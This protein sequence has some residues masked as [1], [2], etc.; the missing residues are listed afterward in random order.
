MTRLV[1]ASQAKANETKVS[2][3]LRFDLKQLDW[4]L[5]KKRRRA[6]ELKSR[7]EY[8][9]KKIEVAENRRREISAE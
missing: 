8:I 7:L 6:E 5:E 1:S 9:T 3:I 2:K 4:Y